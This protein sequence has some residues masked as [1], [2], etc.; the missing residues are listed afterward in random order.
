MPAQVTTTTE[1]NFTRGLI[2]EATG[3]NFPENAA[4]SC[5][6]SEFTLIGDVVR[7]Q[8]IDVEINGQPQTIDR[9]NLAISEY[10]WNNPGGDGNSKLLV[11]QVGS[12]LYFYNI[13]T[14]TLTTPVSSQFLGQLSISSMTVPGVTF[15]S[16][17]ECAFTDGNGFLFVYHPS[18][19]PFYVTYNAGTHA[20]TQALIT[21]NIRDFTGCVDNLGPSTR[22]AT[23]S[24]E[25]QYNLLNQGWVAG[26][27][28]AGVST[29][30]YSFQTGDFTFIIQTGLTIS[31]GASVTVIY[32][33]NTIAAK[34]STQLVNFTA[35]TAGCIGTVVSYTSAT[36]ALV[37]NCSLGSA[38]SVATVIPSSWSLIPSTT[39]MIGTF[40]TA[41]NV[42]PSNADIWWSFKDDT[43]TFNPAGTLSNVTQV[44][45]NAPQ[46]HF[47]LPAFNQ[48]RL[49]VSGTNVQSTVTTSRPTTGTWYAGRVW[50]TGVNAFQDTISDASFY[51]W[52]EN[53]YFSQ[54]VSGVSDF[55][56]CYQVND[57]TSQNLNGLLPTD[58]GVITIVGS[59]TIHKLFPIANGLLVFANN[60]VWF[61]TGSQGIGFAANDYTVTKIS[62]VKVLSQKSFVDVLG[63]PYFWNEE[64]IYQ[65]IPAQGGSLTVVPLTVGTILSFYNQIPLVSKKYAKAAYNPITYVVQWVY[66]TTQETSVT[67]RYAYDGILNYNTYNKAFYPYSIDNINSSINGII[68][69]NF[70]SIGSATPIPVIKYICTTGSNL[71]L[72]DEHDIN[73]VDWSSINYTSTFTTGYKLHGQG[74]KRFQIPYIYV[75]SRNSGYSAYTVQSA[76][77]YGI[78][79]DSNKWSQPQ[80][81]ELNDSNS[82]M[83]FRR[84]KLRGNGIVLQL[85][86]NSVD[87]QPFD[88]IGWSIFE[89]VNAGV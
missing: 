5:I 6:N 74:L 63:L 21:I 9:T 36:G 89:T 59:G 15:D 82:G 41:A 77:D 70:P 20:F 17:L 72:A 25:H 29:T 2:T 8:G 69:I 80:F 56:S 30:P 16:T 62:S 84:I 57:P 53:I 28:W 10:V 33:G 73:Y 47:V 35:G 38:W 79:F 32:T 3:L 55:G 11:I 67:D 75:Y 4:T 22:P 40:A 37:L 51:T 45:G 60:G 13:A 1:N 27:P 81:I 23:L 24:V 48:S 26:A 46:G 31:I 86:F 18:C 44:A 54:V 43:D 58:G 7:R 88:I 66:K 65:V 64:G 19:D 61:I 76:W 78:D 34:N 68:Y 42:Y 52:T 50:Y 87:G 83:I 71:S 12:N 85:M 49:L 39:G 14:V